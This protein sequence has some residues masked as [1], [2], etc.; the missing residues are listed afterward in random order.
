[1][2]KVT[3]LLAALFCTLFASAA[4]ETDTMI[5]RIKAMRCEDCAHKVNV[6]LH[7]DE[8]VEGLEFN[9]ERRTV[10]V[11]YNPAKTN[12]E[13]IKE[14][15]NA[16]GRYKPSAY[17]K[18]EVIRRGMGLQMS[19]M[20]C[21]DCAD[22]ISKK[23]YGMV[24]VDS[25]A[26]HLDKQY[27]FIRYNANK[28]CKAEIKQ[29]LLD[30]GFT[31]T[32]Y[33]TS[34]VIRFAYYNVPEDIDVEEATEQVLAL[35]GVD[36]ATINPKRHSLAI[37]YVTEQTNPEKLLSDIKAMGLKVTVPTTPQCK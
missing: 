6:A 34:N 35:D 21:Q 8:G 32:T 17:D 13:K 3:F 11:E 37:T 14:E 10:I 19:D 23:L 36:D 7:K 4:N 26:P 15:L 5:V 27:T 30:M 24:G 12:P 16:T 29:A 28:T 25:V 9:L 2:K 22:R 18:N 31:P 33:Y 1:M 20:C